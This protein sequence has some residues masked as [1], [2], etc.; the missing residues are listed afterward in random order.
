[1]QG[2]S[3]Q[4]KSTKAPS[5]QDYCEQNANTI[6][7]V[8]PSDNIKAEGNTGGGGQKIIE[9]GV[10][11]SDVKA[12]A[13]PVN[14]PMAAPK[15]QVSEGK[16]NAEGASAL[17]AQKSQAQ[18]QSRASWLVELADVKVSEQ[19]E[20]IFDAFDLND[21]KTV[22]STWLTDFLGRNGLDQSDPRLKSFWWQIRKM[23]PNY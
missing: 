7:S 6:T 17:T 11:V 22:N 15:P 5:W 9:N 20:Q 14:V 3:I 2:K 23:G 18:L 21:T 12:I 10:I 19:V 16:E 1:M 13:S 4:S 8:V